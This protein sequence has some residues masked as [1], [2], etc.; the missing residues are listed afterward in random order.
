MCACTDLRCVTATEHGITIAWTRPRL[1]GESACATAGHQDQVMQSPPRTE[2]WEVGAFD[3]SVP[4]PEPEVA[5]IANKKARL[6][7]DHSLVI[8]YDKK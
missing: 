6:L 3:S 7:G 8:E 2:S 1:S 4:V 5:Q